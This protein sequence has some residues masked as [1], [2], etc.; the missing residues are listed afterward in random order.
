MAKAKHGN[1]AIFV[2][3]NGCP[4]MCSF[5]NQRTIS[6]QS[7]QPDGEFVRKTCEDALNSMTVD[8][9][10]AQIAFFGG[11]FTAID[12]ALMVS[13]LQAAAEYVETGKFAGIRIS[14]RPDCIDEEILSILKRYHVTDIELGAQSMDDR[15]LRLNRR[16]H[17]AEDV[18]KASRL[19]KQAGF[20]LG[21]Q[22]MVG[23]Y[24]ENRGDIPSEG[25]DKTLTERTMY[26]A[27]RIAALKPDGVRI[28]PTAVLKGTELARLFEAGVY[29]PPSVDMA[30]ECCADVMEFFEKKNITVLRVGLHASE[31]VEADVIAGVYHPAFRELCDNELYFRKILRIVEKK[32]DKKAKIYVEPH[33]ISKAVGQKRKNIVRLSSLGYDVCICPREGVAAGEIET[34]S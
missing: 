27:E 31:T 19:I 1:V 24:G 12:R 6:G 7:A 21:L 30:V 33:S 9:Q 13:L 29:F 16:G 10:N 32:A 22:M 26:T 2:P 34:E 23:L 15:V 25:A 8:P 14:T 28:Y 18:E 20:S 17:T 5:C 4:N 11:S 3:H